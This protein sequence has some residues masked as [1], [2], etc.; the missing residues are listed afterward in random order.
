MGVLI[1]MGVL[2]YKRITDLLRFI[3]FTKCAQTLLT[4]DYWQQTDAK[5]FFFSGSK[6]KILH[7]SNL[8]AKDLYV[9]NIGT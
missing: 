2:C 6:K 9:S 5:T 4:T 7:H 8:L 3:K 1:I